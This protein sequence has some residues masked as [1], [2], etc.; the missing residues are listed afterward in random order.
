MY[1]YYSKPIHACF[2]LEHEICGRLQGLVHF[3]Y[4]NCLKPLAIISKREC[5]F[6]REDTVELRYNVRYIIRDTLLTN[7]I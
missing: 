7:A 5:C 4:V 3:N 6:Q 1:N 2:S